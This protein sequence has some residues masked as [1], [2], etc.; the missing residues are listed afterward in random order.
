MSKFKKAILYFFIILCITLGAIHKLN[1]NYIKLTNEIYY[2]KFILDI[3]T[4]DIKTGWF[5]VFSNEE[6]QVD[7][8]MVKYKAFCNSQTLHLSEVKTYNSNNKLINKE[9]NTHNVSAH[10]LSYVNGEIYYKTL[11]K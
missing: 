5:K 6:N 3:N 7:F 1:S 11:C 9:K 4:S 10:Y 8:K 2:K